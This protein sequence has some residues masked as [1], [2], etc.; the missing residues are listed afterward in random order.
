MFLS[1]QMCAHTN[2]SVLWHCCFVLVVPLETVHGILC[3]AAAACV[4]VA[5]SS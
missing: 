4:G 3:V 2:F 5:V 1:F